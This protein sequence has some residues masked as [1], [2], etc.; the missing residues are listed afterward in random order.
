M[1]DRYIPKQFDPAMLDKHLTAANL[2]ISHFFLGYLKDLR[3]EFA[4]DLNL[5]II[6]AEIG[7]HNT[8]P[9]FSEDKVDS[10]GLSKLSADPEKLESLPCCNAFSLSQATGIPRETV[11]RKIKWLLE[12]GWVVETP[13]RGLRVTSACQ[14]HFR[15]DYLLRTLDAFLQTAKNLKTLLA[16]E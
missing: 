5:V 12:K 2:Y 9:Y 3:R 15:K 14:Q 6:L 7:H 16:K 4:G 13:M 8:S 10:E 11:R 1:I